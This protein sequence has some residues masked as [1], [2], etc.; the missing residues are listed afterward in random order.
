[1]LVHPA[2][3]ELNTQ[4]VQET[5]Y[6]ITSRSLPAQRPTSPSLE[7]LAFLSPAI[8]PAEV[9]LS[10]FS[11]LFPFFSFSPALSYRYMRNALS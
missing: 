8:A 6:F 7:F 11:F 10:F 9:T 5:P 4:P 2:A 1:M 3:S